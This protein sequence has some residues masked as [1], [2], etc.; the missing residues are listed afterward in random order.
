MEVMENARKSDRKEKG[1]NKNCESAIEGFT[2]KT[3]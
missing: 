3:I 1:V 2:D